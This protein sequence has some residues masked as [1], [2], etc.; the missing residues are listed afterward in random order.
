MLAKDQIKQIAQEIDRSADE[1]I[2]NC[3]DRFDR[4]QLWE[5]VRRACRAIEAVIQMAAVPAFTGDYRRFRQLNRTGT[6]VAHGLFSRE[7][8]VGKRQRRMI[9]HGAMSQYVGESLRDSPA[10][11]EDCA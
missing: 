8:D 11:R 2:H 4:Q 5:V 6:T 1:R 7:S 9:S 10:P 3:D